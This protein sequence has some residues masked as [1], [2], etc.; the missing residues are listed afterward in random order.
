MHSSRVTVLD[1]L[2]ATAESGNID[3][4]FLFFLEDDVVSSETVKSNENHDSQLV[5][6][7]Y[8][9]TT[10]Y[11]NKTEIEA[12]TSGH[13]CEAKKMSATAKQE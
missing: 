1:L 6:Q 5:N 11:K 8:K 7:K 12:Y 10:S 9:G 2:S 3:L 4:T 13:P